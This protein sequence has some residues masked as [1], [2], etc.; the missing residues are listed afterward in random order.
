[1]LATISRCQRA[2]TQFPCVVV[3]AHNAAA[4]WMEWSVILSLCSFNKL[5]NAQMIG[6]LKCVSHLSHVARN[7]GIVVCTFVCACAC[8]CVK[9]ISA[10]RLRHCQHT[11][12]HDSSIML[13]QTHSHFCARRPFTNPS[14]GARSR[15]ARTHPWGYVIFICIE[16]CVC[17]QRTYRICSIGLRHKILCIECDA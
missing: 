2:K 4:A 12:T 9:E 7:A 8:V 16:V 1:M 17:S 5:F 3:C 14:H 10:E 6:R 15:Q 13:A 11:Q